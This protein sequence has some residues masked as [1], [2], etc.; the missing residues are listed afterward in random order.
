MDEAISMA[1][2]IVT[3]SAEILDPSSKVNVEIHWRSVCLYFDVQWC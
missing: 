3:G 2:V 1:G